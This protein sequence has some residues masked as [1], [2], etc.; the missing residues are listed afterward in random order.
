MNGALTFRLFKSRTRVSSVYVHDCVFTTQCNFFKVPTFQH[1][2]SSLQCGSLLQSF[3]NTKSILQG[4]QLHAYILS[5]GILLENT[6]INTKLSAFYAICGSL[7]EARILFDEITLKN[8]FLWNSMIRGYAC[9]GFSVNSLVL[10]R[11]ML[12]LGCKPDNFTYPFVIKACGD[13]LLVETGKRI[14]CE[15]VVTG[16]ELDRYVAN[17]LIAMYSNFGDMKIA[18]KLFDKMIIRDLTSWN[19][20]ISGYVK[21]HNSI[22]GLK[23]FDLMVNTGVKPD[24]S[25]LVSV[26]PGCTY[27]EALKQGREIHGYIVK[28][29]IGLFNIDVLNSLIDMY[30]KCKSRVGA[31]KLFEKMITRD[32]VT[33]NTMISGYTWSGDAYQSLRFFCRMILEGGDPDQV[34]LVSLLGSCSQIS[35]LQF[36]TSVH[37]FLVRKGFI[38]YTILGTALVDMYAKCGNLDCSY[39]IFNEI[40]EKTPV[41]WTAMIGGFGLHGKGREAISVFNEMKVKGMKPD[42][43]TFT[44]ILSACSHAGLVDEGRRIFAQIV[45]ECGC[46]MPTPEHYSCMVDLLGRAGYLDEAYEFI[47]SM[48]IQPSIDVWATLLS[49]CR[50]K[51]NVLLAE[52]AAE[53]IFKLNPKNVGSYILLSNIYASQKKWEEVERVRLMVRDLGLKKPHGCT[54]IELD[55][56]V[57]RFLVGDQSHSESKYIYEKLEELRQKIME[58]GYTP[59]T[60]SV[61]YDVEEAVKEK[62]LWDHIERL[63]IAFALIHTGPNTVIRISKNLRV[64]GDCHTAIKLISKVT[65]REIIMRD[66][67]RFHHFNNG[68]CSCGDYW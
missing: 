27:L 13:L 10:Y 68:V 33:W 9:N 42:A 46:R 39:R 7:R 41:S 17:S 32:N 30:F 8:S 57:H 49:A 63:A 59:D 66:A 52:V 19:T 62:M 1:P 15:I 16:F 21:N 44:T 67:H 47:K 5:C 11:E 23:V 48:K 51:C 12:S 31:E 56:V 14:H 61:F 24:C 58:A 20:T 22:E 35:A 18:R 50:A 28:S 40:P 2:L 34:T 38:K 36:G 6:Y 45:Q 55:K 60:S 65:C 3:T 37:S 29:S 26:L 43:V 25:T 64:C 4:K 54:F 53:N